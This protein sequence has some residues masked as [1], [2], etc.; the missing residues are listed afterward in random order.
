[1][2]ISFENKYLGPNVSKGFIALHKNR[3]ITYIATGLLGIYM[4]IFLFNLFN[5]NLRSVA[6]FFLVGYLLFALTVPTATKYM[7]TFGF[8]K[9]L[10]TATVFGALYYVL[11]Y[12]TNETNY[13][14]FIPFILISLTLYRLLYWIPFNVDLA[15]FMDKDNRAR[16]IS[17][18]GATKNAVAIFTPML[19]GYIITKFSFSYLFAI[20]VILYLL[21]VIPLI[22]IPRTKE[23]FTWSIRTTWK[24]F[25]SKKRRPEMLAFAADGG[26]GVVGG[27]I[28]PIFMFQIL[29]GNY[30]ELGII[31]SV[32]VAITIILQLT[33]GSYTDNPK[34]KKSKILKYGTI[35]YAVGWLL[36]IFIG[37]AFQIFIIDAYHKLTKIFMRIP[38]DAIVNEKSSDEGHNIDEFTVIREIATNAGRVLMLLLIVGI[39]YFTTIQTAF[40]LGAFA[41]ISL[42]T[43]RTVKVKLA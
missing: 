31:S 8:K 4:P 25:F 32:I 3:T 35:F 36:K 27:I 17:I 5:Q 11:F 18:M 26:E 22:K 16:E 10:Q 19:A 43:I 12:F 15:K 38:F 37:T 1:M 20:A 2:N 40:V 29:N 14:I 7:N 41:S 39:S 34:N 9:A 13:Q 28:W 21:S 33:V 23:K 42:N 30:L 24:N 6:W